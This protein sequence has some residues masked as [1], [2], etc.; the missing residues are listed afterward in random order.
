LV[1]IIGG[2]QHVTSMMGVNMHFVVKK[3]GNGQ[4]RFTLVASNGQVVATSET[5][6][7]K[8]S[9]LNTIKSIQNNAGDARVEDETTA[10]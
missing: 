6:T 10:G 3:T 7:R 5:Y 1:R 4:F 2:Y 9:A 8:Q